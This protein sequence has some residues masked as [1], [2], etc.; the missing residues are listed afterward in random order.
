MAERLAECCRFGFDRDQFDEAEE[1]RYATGVLLATLA[2]V[3]RF[4]AAFNLECRRCRRVRAEIERINLE[5][6][7]LCAVNGQLGH[8]ETV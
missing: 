4:W 8:R 5:Q 3:A 6:I 7:A 1:S 2:H